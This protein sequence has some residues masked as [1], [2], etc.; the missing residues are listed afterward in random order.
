MR[1]FNIG[2]PDEGYKTALLK[3]YNSSS[4]IELLETYGSRTRSSSTLIIGKKLKQG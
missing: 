4:I 3:K 2:K 1:N